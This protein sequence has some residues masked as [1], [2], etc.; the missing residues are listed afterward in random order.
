MLENLS[1]RN[2]A[3]SIGDRELPHGMGHHYRDRPRRPV[4]SG[5]SHAENPPPLRSNALR[6][7]IEL[8]W[9]TVPQE[10]DPKGVAILICRSGFAP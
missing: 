1:W 5:R 8:N 7:L 2:V 4:V 10:N 9:Q 6:E 3:V